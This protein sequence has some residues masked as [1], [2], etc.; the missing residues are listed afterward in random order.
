M[1]RKRISHY[2]TSLLLQ[3]ILSGAGTS[4]FVRHVQLQ[5]KRHPKIILW[6]ILCIYRI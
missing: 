3:L 2:Q 4:I 5:S 1:D 6:I